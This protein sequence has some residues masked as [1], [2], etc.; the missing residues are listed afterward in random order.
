M[1]KKKKKFWETPAG[2]IAIIALVG[3][4][5]TAIVKTA[6]YINLP[7]RVEAS[8]GE[9]VDLKQIILKQQTIND[10]Y[11][12]REQQQ[13]IQQQPYYP[14]QQQYP[15]NA[16]AYQEPPRRCTD[17]WEGKEYPVDCVTW[18]WL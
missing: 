7:E 9:I 13:Q 15:N 18:E 17:W 16:P 14:K 8:E 5:G 4:L 3:G 2:I 1:T 12:Q 10:F 11:Y 6:V